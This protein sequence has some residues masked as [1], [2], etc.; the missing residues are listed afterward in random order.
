MAQ[1][2]RKK[3]PGRRGA[4][5]KRGDKKRAAGKAQKAKPSGK[6]NPPEVE[7]LRLIGGTKPGAQAGEIF[8]P[9]GPAVDAK[10]FLLAV[11][12]AQPETLIAMG[13]DRM[14]TIAQRIAAASVVIPFTHQRKPVEVVH[15]QAASWMEKIQSAQHR[16]T[17]MRR[18]VES[19]DTGVDAAEDEA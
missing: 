13:I 9:R 4:G 12:N 14:P 17:S 18:T 7:A 15:R 8:P 6:P 19:G 16:V 2:P 5:K 1:A 11:M 10:E 3:T